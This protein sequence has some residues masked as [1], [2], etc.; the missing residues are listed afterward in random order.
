MKSAFWISTEYPTSYVNLTWRTYSAKRL[1]NSITIYT[2]KDLLRVCISNEIIMKPRNLNFIGLC[3]VQLYLQ[4]AV[5]IIWTHFGT[6][7]LISFRQCA[8]QHV[9]HILTWFF[10]SSWFKR[11]R[12][13]TVS[14]TQ[15]GCHL[16]GMLCVNLLILFCWC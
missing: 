15:L 11:H 2:M 9:I 16:C 6:V 13:S 12:K 8:V 5:F 7:G 4:H 1:W 3:I 10:V 14:R